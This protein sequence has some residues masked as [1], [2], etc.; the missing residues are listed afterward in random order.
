M[1]PGFTRIL[2]CPRVCDA[3]PA[4]DVE[5][6]PDM[7]VPSRFLISEN[8]GDCAAF[9]LGTQVP[10]ESLLHFT[11]IPDEAKELFMQFYESVNFDPTRN[12]ANGLFEL[13]KS[14]GAIYQ[15]WPP[16]YSEYVESTSTSNVPAISF[17]VGNDPAA[18]VSSS[19]STS[20][21]ASPAQAVVQGSP[22]KVSSAT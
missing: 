22:P 17:S 19:T 3:L 5:L 7:D 15:M 20:V 10:I 6:P 9:F 21:A 18:G 11:Q 4:T 2:I 8:S 14:Q 12:L 16:V 1:N 13:L